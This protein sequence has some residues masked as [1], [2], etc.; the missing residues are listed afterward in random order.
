MR[1][2]ESLGSCS[3]TQLTNAILFMLLFRTFCFTS[4]LICLGIAPTQAQ[5]WDG[6]DNTSDTIFRDGAVG[7]GTTAPK[8]PFEV[9]STGWPTMILNR[10]H[11]NR[12]PKLSFAGEGEEVWSIIGRKEAGGAN[13]QFQIRDGSGN[14][15]FHIDGESGNVGIGTTTPDRSLDVAGHIALDNYAIFS[16]GGSSIS[17]GNT[18]I[19]IAN[20]DDDIGVNIESNGEFEVTRDDTH[21]FVVGDHVKIVRDGIGNV[22]IGTKESP[23]EKLS[24]AGNVL[25]EEVIV[26]PQSEWADFVFE[27]SYELPGLEE[28]SSFIEKEGHLPDVPSAEEVKEE[29]LRVGEMDAALLQKVE[30]LTLYAI[31]Q[32]ERLGVAMEQLREEK[33]RSSRQST[34]VERQATQIDSLEEENRRLRR[35]VEEQAEELRRQKKQLRRQQQQIDQLMQIVHGQE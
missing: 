20:E 18:G 3:K 26:K 9:V 34:R 13:N 32:K 17:L 7:I 8:A 30:E 23:P 31:E 29:G 1:E 19:G 10:E 27:E 12:D 28:V 21:L 11:G 14:R 35:T 16:P 6:P 33:D 15:R 5:K 25:A 2:G 4:L 24:V 22:G